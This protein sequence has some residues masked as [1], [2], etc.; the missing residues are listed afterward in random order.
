MHRSTICSMVNSHSSDAV[1]NRAMSA[2]VWSLKLA[3]AAA[4]AAAADDDDDDEAVFSAA[5][6]CCA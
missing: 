6:E 4:A 1:E 5:S 3:A 2:S